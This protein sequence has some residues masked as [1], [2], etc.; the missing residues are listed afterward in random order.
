MLSRTQ[1]INGALQ[2]IS[3]N[4][5]ADPNENSESARQAKAVYDQI[6]AAEIEA[7]AWF[8]AKKQVSL[9][10]SGD[11]PLF[12]Y[13]RAYTLPADFIRLVELDGRWMFSTFREYDANPRPTYEMN[14]RAL[15]TDIAAP[16][17]LGYLSRDVVS[18]P[19]KWTPLFAN[20]ASAALA[21]RLAMPLTK[22]EGMVSLAEKIYQKELL[23]ARRANAI[24]MPPAQVPDG[25]WM[26]ARIY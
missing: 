12:K 7:H 11:V 10:Q 2:I 4:L 18:D 16:L 19:A 5:I 6:V 3:A 17:L 9:P 20:V 24:Q 15:Y 8:F 1:V 22:S 23:R 21:V 13:A 14:G 26:L 25:S